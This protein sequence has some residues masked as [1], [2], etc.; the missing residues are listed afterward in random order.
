MQRTVYTADAIQWMSERGVLDGCSIVTSLPD[1]TELAGVDRA[2]WSGWFVDAAER[3]ARAVTRGGL[4]VFY[5]TDAKVEG[6]W[7]DKAALVREGAARAGARCVFHWIVLRA[8]A[9]TR[10]LSRAGYSHLIGFSQGA[11]LDLSKPFADVI[12]DAG[13]TT[14]TR[15]MGANACRAAC[16]AVIALTDTRIIVDPFCGHGTV[17]AVAN[18]LGLDVIGVELG[19]RR[20]RKARTLTM[21]QLE[22][23]GPRGDAK[24]AQHHEA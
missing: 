15:G 1:A 9:G 7:F 23:D 11:R 10:T 21:E 12:A 18:A 4:A 6:Q 13:P 20:A 5:Q 3:C 2:Q 8:P 17:L 19:R 14:W 24:P 22:S 16:E